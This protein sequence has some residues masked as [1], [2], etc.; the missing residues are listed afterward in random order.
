MD[1]RDRL[2]MLHDR[3][4]IHWSEAADLVGMSISNYADMIFIDDEL[5]AVVNFEDVGVICDK[6]NT[7]LRWLFQDLKPECTAEPFGRAVLQA[8]FRRHLAARNIPAFE[9][10]MGY[11]CARFLDHIEEIE[12]WNLDLVISICGELGLDWRAFDFKL[13]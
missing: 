3:L 10:R 9:D 11:Y 2:A 6:L 12:G 13:P 8:F 1:H 5:V 7:S 4:G